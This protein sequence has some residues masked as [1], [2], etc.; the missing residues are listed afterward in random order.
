[1][2]IEIL[3][4][5]AINKGSL[6]GTCHVKLLDMGWTIR[7]VSIFDSNG[8][9]GIGMPARQYEQ[10]GKKKY[11]KYFIPETP[12]IGKAFETLVLAK[13]EKYLQTPSVH[14]DELPF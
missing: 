8:V 1:M 6:M 2:N 11:Y 5:K 7:D 9:K 12:E 3:D 4:Y 10:D 14:N 13:L